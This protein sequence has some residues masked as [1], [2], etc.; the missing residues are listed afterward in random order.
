MRSSPAL[1]APTP[2]PCVASTVRQRYYSVPPTGH[3]TTSR[4]DRQASLLRDFDPKLVARL[5]LVDV[6]PHATDLALTEPK[7]P[8]TVELDRHAA[9]LADHPHVDP[10]DN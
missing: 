9:A 10:D 4:R 7:A 3:A 6:Q 1:P 8:A 5:L 2:K